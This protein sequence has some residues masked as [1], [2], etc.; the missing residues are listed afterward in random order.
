MLFIRVRGI[1]SKVK[2]LARYGIIHGVYEWNSA[3]MVSGGKY[4]HE[5]GLPWS[6]ERCQI[7]WGERNQSAGFKSLSGVSIMGAVST[8]TSSEIHPLNDFPLLE[9]RSRFFG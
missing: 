4:A 1:I 8:R 3:T 9:G 5:Q 7:R 2:P 6:L